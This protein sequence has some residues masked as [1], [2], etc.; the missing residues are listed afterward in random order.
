MRGKL[1]YPPTHLLCSHPQNTLKPNRKEKLD[2]NN[3][4]NDSEKKVVWPVYLKW[5]IPTDIILTGFCS[6]R[7]RI[8]KFGSGIKLEVVNEIIHPE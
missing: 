3:H 4:D 1:P 2:N 7:L 5:H 6:Q 8:W